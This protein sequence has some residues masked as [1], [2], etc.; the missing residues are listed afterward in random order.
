MT[1]RELLFAIINSNIG[2]EMRRVLVS[3]V[4]QLIKFEEAMRQIAKVNNKRD[5]YSNEI[6]AIIVQ[7]MEMTNANN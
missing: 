1:D 6:D 4:K 7:A 2:G 5:R 3:T